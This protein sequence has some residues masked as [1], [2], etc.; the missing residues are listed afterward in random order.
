MSTSRYIHKARFADFALSIHTG[1]E[2]NTAR[3]A[4]TILTSRQ[5][6]VGSKRQGQLAYTVLQH[7]TTTFKLTSLINTS[8]GQIDK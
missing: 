7:R 2:L 3:K 1:S 8:W 5:S 4:N 6:F